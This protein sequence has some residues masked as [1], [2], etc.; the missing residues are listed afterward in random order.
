MTKG[1][2][3]KHLVD[4]I[5]AKKARKHGVVVWYDPAGAFRELID[6]LAIERVHVVRLKGSFFQIRYE[7]EDI[8][9]RLDRN[10]IAGE[11][12]VIV[13]VDRAPL[14]KRSD[15]L[16]GLEKAGTRFDWSLGAVVRDALKS[17]VPRET[18]D[19]WLS[20]EK[21]RLEDIERLSES[22]LSSEMSAVAVVFETTVAADVAIQ[23]LSEPT[24]VTEVENK[25]AFEELRILLGGGLGLAVDGITSQETLRKRLGRHVL[26]TEFISGISGGAVPPELAAISADCTASQRDACCRAARGLRDRWRSREDYAALAESVEAEFGLRSL[27][28]HVGAL[29]NLDTFPFA[30]EIVL[31]SLGEQAK[32][33]QVD[34]ALD[35]VKEREGSFWSVVDP[36]RAIQW[37]TA[38]TALNLC[39]EGTRVLEEVKQSKISPS[40]LARSYAHGDGGRG[41]WFTADSLERRLEWLVATAEVE[42]Q[43]EDLIGLAR[44]DTAAPQTH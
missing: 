34:T 32:R 23:Y 5:L 10:S 29:G 17:Q 44:N 15:L 28:L 33:G 12:S 3:T 6:D 21:I 30:E 19:A 24:L 1:P 2:I 38:Q 26:L 40:V 41:R 39:R 20:N 31:R 25:A 37:Q 16:L 13:Y 27:K 9:G 11:E 42:F 36:V 7:A 43:V 18:L 4:E 8:F 22:D 35:R 14:D